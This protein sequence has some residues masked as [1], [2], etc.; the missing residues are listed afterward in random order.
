[1]LF[2]RP[3]GGY[4]T[5]VFAGERVFLSPLLLPVARLLYRLAKFDPSEK[6]LANLRQGS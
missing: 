5:R 1:L 6:T 2:I 4:L 3:F